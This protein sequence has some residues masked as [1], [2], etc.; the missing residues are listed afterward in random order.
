MKKV[1]IVLPSEYNKL[2]TFLKVFV[3]ELTSSTITNYYFYYPNKKL[4]FNKLRSIILIL[5]YPVRVIK[6]FKFL[7]GN[8]SVNHKLANIF[9]N[10]NLL[11]YRKIDIIHYTFS[12][13]A[14]GNYFAGKI[15]NAT[16]SIGFRGYDITYFPLNHPNC[17]SI[18]YWKNIDFIQT[19]SEDLYKCALKWGMNINTPFLKITAAVNDNFIL[20]VRDLK[21]RENFESKVVNL[22]FIGRLHWKKGLESLVR[23]LILSRKS[24]YDFQLSIVGDGPEFEKLSYL[25]WKYN[26]H[27]QIHILGKKSQTKI[28]DLIDESDIILAPSIQEG[29]SNAV[30]EAQAR[31]K[32]CIVSDAEGMNEVIENNETGFIFEEFD[33]LKI[34]DLIVQYVNY[35]YSER[36]DISTKTVKRI[37]EKFRRSKQIS[38]WEY[39]FNEFIHV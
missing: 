22:L 24:F 17:Y 4:N 39:Y 36:Y 10:I 8:L 20:D 15:L 29:C 19:N 28:L 14:V 7:E 26:L 37:G 21:V 16:I 35:D 33:E 38:E 18:D 1:L 30:L 32:F 2:E 13:L 23:L 12:N 27:N 3:D 6:Y 31:G 11:T 25:I 5:L 34:F 9:V